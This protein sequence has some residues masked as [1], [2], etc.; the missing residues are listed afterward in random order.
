ML[1][2][3][4][5]KTIVR[6]LPV[7]LAL[8]T[9]VYGATAQCTVNWNDVHQ[10]I[11]GFGG[12]VV[13]LSPAS[14]DPVAGTNMDTLFRT[15]NA[16]QLG[17]TLLRVRIDPS[18]NWA[19]ALSDAQ[20]AIARGARVLATPWSPPASMKDNDNTTG[21]SLLPAQY[22]NYAAYLNGFAGY[23]AANGAPL[24]AISVQNEPDAS[25][26]Y[27]SASWNPTQLQTFCH[28]NAGAITNAPVLMPESQSYNTNYS[29]PTLND[30]IAATNVTFIAGHLYGSTDAGVPVVDYPNAHNKGKPT[31]MTEFLVNDQT[32]GTAITTAMQIH[33]CMTVGNMSAYIWWKC[34]GDANGLVNASGV[35]QIR[36]FVMAQW[37][38]FVRTNYFRIGATNNTSAAVSAYKDSSSTAFAIVAINTN[39]TASINQTF[40]LTNFTAASVT[41]WITSGTLSLAAQTAVAVSNAS[42]TCNL[43]AM[44]VVTF[45]GQGN[46]PPAIAPVANRTN[47]VGV[48]LLITNVA[49][50]SDLPPQTLTFSPANTWPA[51]ATL[52]SSNGIFTWRPLVSQ[53]NTT[54]QIE[55]RV[56]DN[57]T[58][59][60]SATNSF[61]VIVNPV[62]NPVVSSPSVFGG[63][64]NMTVNG[65]QGPDYT[66]QTTTNLTTSWQ[67]LFTTNSPL[68][69]CT[70]ADTNLIDPARF[71]RFQI[72]P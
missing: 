3:Q 2:K 43:P 26:D 62:T 22:A 36:G 57:G 44:S 58:P 37:S 32:I 61:Y 1:L 59:N 53:A 70:F 50:D 52:N 23:M 13:F 4:P 38:R 29:E 20:K 68:M 19:N 40:I 41:P 6:Y 42:F 49:T 14:L 46:T 31:W 69:P 47:N 35:P 45:V 55:V 5:V 63:Q 12:G 16:N 56:T 25:V 60:L 51:N 54:N 28:D 27:E 17:L 71:Y 15:N 65:P 48:T 66:L 10:R 33:D 34:L 11:D 67:A 9:G 8:F 18:S 72:G 24:A 7:V 30:P 64:I 21:G 39:A